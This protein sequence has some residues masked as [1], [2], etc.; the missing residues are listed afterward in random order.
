[1]VKGNNKATA[2]G[3]LGKNKPAVVHE[4]NHG[5]TK[6]ANTGLEFNNTLGAHIVEENE[7]WFY[8]WADTY[9]ELND[10]Y[11]IPTEENEPGSSHTFTG[12][13]SIFKPI[14]TKHN[15]RLKTR[16]VSEVPTST[17][18][19]FCISERQ[20]I[21]TGRLKPIIKPF[22]RRWSYMLGLSFRGYLL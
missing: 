12:N 9:D 10:Y 7:G 2:A 17:E 5:N 14:K 3:T 19:D 8:E 22:D 11:H 16:L 13:N 20:K 6:L 15:G 1:M 4:N 21:N 18:L